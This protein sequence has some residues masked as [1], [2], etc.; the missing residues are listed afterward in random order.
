MINSPPPKKKELK[1]KKG[2]VKGG[3]EGKRENSSKEGRGVGQ[4]YGYPY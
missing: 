4:K 1:G 3:R 2:R